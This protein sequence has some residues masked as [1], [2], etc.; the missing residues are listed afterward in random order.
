MNFSEFLRKQLMRYFI[1]VTSI[2]LLMGIIGIQY[3]PNMRFG[4]EAYFSP[5]L[6][7]LIGVIPSFVTYAKKELSLRQMKIRK[8][9]Q[10]L[11]LEVLILSIAKGLKIVDT[12]MIATMAFSIFIIFVGV[13]IIEWLIDQKKAQELTEDLKAFQETKA[14]RL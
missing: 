9:I 14:N 6:F 1:I 3:E 7:G 5:L 8:V 13:H 11:V 4:Y 10:F 2:T 12:H